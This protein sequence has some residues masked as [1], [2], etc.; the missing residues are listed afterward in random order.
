MT[1][2]GGFPA[3]R[4]TS[5]GCNSSACNGLRSNL[6]LDLASYWLKVSP[7][8]DVVVVPTWPRD[9]TFVHSHRAK[10]QQCGLFTAGPMLEGYEL[11]MFR[12][13]SHRPWS[14]NLRQVSR[15]RARTAE[16]RSSRQHNQHHIKSFSISHAHR[17]IDRRLVRVDFVSKSSEPFLPNKRGPERRKML[18]IL[19]V[20]EAPEICAFQPERSH[21]KLFDFVSCFHFPLT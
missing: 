21:R 9:Q 15:S 13:P 11:V 10:D 5:E 7:S 4:E 1:L 16:I 14:L 18:A 17:G 6:H 12:F 2:W 20:D 3:V 8:L 19:L